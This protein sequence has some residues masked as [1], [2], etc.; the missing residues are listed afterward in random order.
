MM[1]G[2]V[3]TMQNKPKKVLSDNISVVET[4]AKANQLYPR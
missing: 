3:V 2:E 4:K 1:A